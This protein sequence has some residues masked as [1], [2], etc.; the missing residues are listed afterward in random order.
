MQPQPTGINR[1]SH[2]HSYFLGY[3]TSLVVSDPYVPDI[4]V[5]VNTIDNLYYVN[6]W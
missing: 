3:S 1:V 5:I 2:V 6:Y 4:L